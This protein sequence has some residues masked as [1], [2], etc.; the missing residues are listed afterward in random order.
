MD[1]MAPALGGDDR[2]LDPGQELLALGM[3]QTEIRQIAQIPGTLDLQ[4]IDAVRRTLG[5][6]LHQAQHPPHS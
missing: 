1:R 6:A 2:L 4:H 5:P 3:R